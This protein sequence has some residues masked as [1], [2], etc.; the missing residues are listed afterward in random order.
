MRCFSYID[1]TLQVFDKI[2]F[3]NEAVGETFNLGPDED[4]ITINELA[5]MTANAT[6]YNGEH[7]PH[8]PRN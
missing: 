6:G 5:N 2:C 1:D 8:G 7:Q 3:S 4:Y